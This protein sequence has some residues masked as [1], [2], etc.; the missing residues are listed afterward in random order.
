MDLIWMN[1]KA[2]NISGE[3]VE[4]QTRNTPLHIYYNIIT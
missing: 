3:L 2:V 4:T 1:M